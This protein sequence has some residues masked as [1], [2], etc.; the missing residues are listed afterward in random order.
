MIRKIVPEIQTEQGRQPV[1]C[2]LFMSNTEFW[3]GPGIEWTARLLPLPK[4]RARKP[5]GG[6]LRRTGKTPPRE[7]LESASSA[8]ASDAREWQERFSRKAGAFAKWRREFVTFASLTGWVKMRIQSPVKAKFSRRSVWVHV[9]ST[10]LLM[11]ALALGNPHGPNIRPGN[12]NADISGGTGTM[13][14]RQH[15]QRVIIDW[16]DFSVDA[17]ELLK[18]VQDNTQA[19]ALNKVIGNLPSNILGP[20]QANGKIFLVNANGI[21]VGK[22]GVIKTGGFLAS[23]L[24]LKD[25]AAF[26]R[27]DSKLTFSGNS[28]AAIVNAGTIHSESDIFLVAKSVSND[29]LLESLNGKVGIGAGAQVTIYSVSRANGQIEIEIPI[30]DSYFR[31]GGTIKAALAEF[32]TTGAI[33][34]SPSQAVDLHSKSVLLASLRNTQSGKV[35]NTGSIVLKKSDGSG[36]SGIVRTGNF[37]NSGPIAAS[38]TTGPGGDFQ[39]E[40]GVFQ[41]TAAGIID[42]SG[43]SGGT[44]SIV[45]SDAIHLDGSLL[46]KGLTGAGGKISLLTSSYDQAATG[47][48]S[49]DGVAAGGAVSLFA[50]TGAQVKGNITATGSGGTVLLQGPGLNP[51]ATTTSQSGAPTPP[52]PPVALALLNATVKAENVTFDSFPSTSISNSSVAATHITLSNIGNLDINTSLLQGDGGVSIIARS[53]SLTNSTVKA[54]GGM[55]S[56]T[57]PG[58]FTMANSLIDAGQVE[59]T[60]KDLLESSSAISSPGVVTIKADDSVTLK[61]SGVVGLSVSLTGTNLMVQRLPTFNHLYTN[62]NYRTFITEE[63]GGPSVVGADLDLI[64][65]FSDS[66]TNKGSIIYGGRSISG[67]VGILQNLVDILPVEEHKYRRVGIFFRKKDF[68]L[69][70]YN[71]QTNA[72]FGTNGKLVL[73]ATKV[74]NTGEISAALEAVLS[75]NGN[76]TNGFTDKTVTTPI[77]QGNPNEIDLANQTYIDTV[78]ALRQNALGLVS[79]DLTLNN[80]GLVSLADYFGS[81]AVNGKSITIDAASLTAATRNGAVAVTGSPYLSSAWTTDVAQWNGLVT[82][83]QAFLQAHPEIAFGSTL[84]ASQRALVKVPIVWFENTGNGNYV[85]KVLLPLGSNTFQPGGTIQSQG[86]ATITADQF[87]NSGFVTVGGVL[88]FNVNGFINERRTA[89]QLESVKEQSLFGSTTTTVTVDELQGGGVISAG[90]IFINAKGD[91]INKGAIDATGDV[92]ITAADFINEAVS[93]ET[94]IFQHASAVERLFGAKSYLLGETLSPA[95]INAGGNISISANHIDEIGARDI[96]E[97]NISL[98]A[99]DGISSSP[100][101]VTFVDSDVRKVGFS[102]LR[103][104][105][106]QIS[107]TL[108]SLL[109]SLK[110]D[111]TITVANGD[112]VGIA[113]QISAAKAVDISASGNVGLN[114]VLTTNSSRAGAFGISLT[115]LNI[116]DSHQSS[117]VQEAHVAEIL[118]GTVSISAGEDV[119]GTAPTIEGK[120]GVIINAGRDLRFGEVNPVSTFKESGWNVGVTAKVDGIVVFG[121]NPGGSKFIDTIPGADLFSSQKYHG[122]LDETSSYAI[123]ALNAWE[124]LVATAKNVNNLAADIQQGSTNTYGAELQIGTHESKQKTVSSVAPEITSDNGDFEFYTGRDAEFG[125]GAQ[126]MTPNGLVLGRV[127]RNF[128]LASGHVSSEETNSSSGVTLDVGYTQGRFGVTLGGSHSSGRS[129]FE[130]DTAASIVAN[131]VDLTIGANATLKGSPILAN[132]ATIRVA[133][134]LIL[135]SLQ[136]LSSSHSSSFS[137]SATVW[138][139]W[140]GSANVSLAEAK[141]QLT[142]AVAELQTQGNLALTVGGTTSM[143]AS[144]INSVNGQLE[145]STGSLRSYTLKDTSKSY[146]VSAGG[147]AGGGNWSGHGSF[148]VTDFEELRNSWIGQRNIKI[149]NGIMPANIARSEASANKVVRRLDIGF[150]V[151]SVLLKAGDLAPDKLSQGL[152][153]IG[154]A[155]TG[156]VDAAQKV[157]DNVAD[158][159][160]TYFGENQP[161]APVQTVTNPV[162]AQRTPTIDPKENTPTGSST[163]PPADQAETGDAGKASAITRTANTN[164]KT[165]V[166]TWSSEVDA[167]DIAEQADLGKGTST[168]QDLST[169]LILGGYSLTPGQRAQL[170]YEQLDSDTRTQLEAAQQST[171]VD[172]YVHILRAIIGQGSEE[173]IGVN[174]DAWAANT[175]NGYEARWNL[176]ANAYASDRNYNYNQFEAVVDASA[177]GLAKN[178]K[179]ASADPNSTPLT[180]ASAFASDVFDVS[181]VVTLL[182]STVKTVGVKLLD[183]G[184]ES[185][186]S[187]RPLNGLTTVDRTAM[188]ESSAVPASGGYETFFRSMSSENYDTFLSTG[189]IPATGETFIS[190]TAEFSQSYKGVLVKFQMSEGTT[191]ALMDI[192]VRARGANAASLFPDLPTV[193]SGWGQTNALFKPE[194]G[195]INI[196]L[197]NGGALDLFNDSIRGFETIGVN[198]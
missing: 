93:G 81:D 13:T 97:E 160:K 174:L 82:N 106:S 22:S 165:N 17:G 79:N 122:G 44:L 46:A 132:S 123:R 180:R 9:F 45:A 140:G 62:G 158:K 141:S 198:K 87:Y 154:N 157:A 64:L 67:N 177:D 173:V 11:V 151:D 115:S 85:P 78:S 74:V 167:I 121:A 100:A 47:I 66:V 52:P 166:G 179:S 116:S 170:K 175:A 6:L 23:T 148:S 184:G 189:R 197:G 159:V 32:A 125:G 77:Q 61:S 7:L 16:Q 56:A 194:G 24:H 156:V 8:F 103:S 71:L 105:E 107:V 59:M 176:A 153:T 168:L 109:Q 55:F 131:N 41:Q 54:E 113:P 39:I 162:V 92:T 91:V 142:D 90:S 60:I 192:G 137:G 37:T 26:M 50:S 185:L 114:A 27:G 102:G 128:T 129:K 183:L 164:G 143:T 20:I 3:C 73:I 68:L 163:A 172:S 108:P 84:T 18:F 182:E 10:W 70:A 188:S 101:I 89:L 14:V 195:Q 38:S 75:V 144:I 135:Q 104:S 127:G 42:L 117:V 155:A 49:A 181:V 171:G 146:S 29:G 169:N 80:Q 95:E 35:T 124:D 145:F 130:G 57:V 111:V 65:D 58:S 149:G 96:A 110:G 139:T 99:R 30:A 2:G 88:T 5:T 120:N 191:D 152:N 12:G 63:T 43:T 25:E 98:F 150:Q 83:A 86:N 19:V 186:Q 33:S 69:A 53:A 40:T 72:F 190:P 119:T 193:E 187:L 133:N 1:K 34:K 4:S 21:F 28:T 136:N 112:Y 15:G 196:G 134:D 118:G 36:G 51:T 147:S 138:G 126:I 178:Y 48:V 31:N 94:L 76:V 161:P